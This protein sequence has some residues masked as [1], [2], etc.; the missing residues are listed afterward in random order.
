M[1]VI[2]ARFGLKRSIHDS[3]SAT[4]KWLGCAGITQ[5]VDDPEIEVFQ[6]RPALFGNVVEIGRVGGIAHA[7]TE[8][9]NV[10]R[11]GPERPTA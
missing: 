7:I 6:E 2:T 4:L 8:R 9:G 3:A 10:G 11:A 1:L 5:P